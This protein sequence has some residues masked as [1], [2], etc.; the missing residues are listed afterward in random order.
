MAWASNPC[1]CCKRCREGS[2]WYKDDDRD[3][4]FPV[5]NKPYSDCDDLR[6]DVNPGFPGDFCDTSGTALDANCDGTIDDFDCDGYTIGQGDCD[7]NDASVNPAA[8]DVGDIDGVTVID[9]NCDGMPD[10]PSP[11]TT[12]DGDGD[13]YTIS[14]GDC[15]DNDPTVYPGAADVCDTDGVT[16]IDKNCD[17]MTDSPSPCDLDGDG[18]G[19]TIS[20]GDCDDSDPTVNPGAPDVCDTDGVTVIDK[21]CDGVPD[22]PS[23]C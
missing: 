21:N 22:S 11:C 15:D 5:P 10:S 18:D 16:V 13:G 12:L 14:Q 20:Q 4:W 9:K 3:G 2:K 17:G 6:D 8:A 1:K 7:D 19:Y 23:P